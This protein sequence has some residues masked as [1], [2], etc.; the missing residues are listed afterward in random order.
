MQKRL[1]LESV[2]L[3]V[4]I[5]NTLFATENINQLWAETMFR[6]KQTIEF[7]PE[8]DDSYGVVFRDLNKDR[9]A[10]LYVVRF[11]NLNR[12][13][14][15]KGPDERF[16]DFTIQSGLGGNLMPRKRYNLE[17]GTS[18]VDFDNNGWP[19]ILIAGWRVLT[20]FKHQ[21]HL[22]FISEDL[23]EVF[24]GPVDANAGVWA[25]INLDGNL[26]LFIT[27]EHFYNRLLINLG[28]GRL[29]SAEDLYDLDLYPAT[30]Q[31]AAF[32]DI[33]NDGYPDLYVCNWFAPDIFYKNIK[34]EKYEPIELNLPHLKDSL[35]SNGICFGDIDN[36][37][38]LDMVVTDRNGKSCLYRNDTSPKDSR[39]R[40][41]DITK[42]AG[43][44]NNWPSY[45]SVIADLNNDGFQDIF[46]T[47]IGP[48][49]FYLNNSDTNFSLIFQ[50]EL[51][52]FSK[53]QN[54]STGTAVADLDDDGDLDL[55]VANKDTNSILYLNPLNNKDFIRIHLEG[56]T[57]NRDAIGTKIWL[58]RLVDDE[59]FVLKAFREISGGSGYLSFGE[60]IA[61]FGVQASNLYQANIRFPSGIEK[62]LTE[63]EPGNSYFVEEFGG[64]KKALVQTYRL[65]VVTTLK[66]NFWLNL[67]LFI[68]MVTLVGGFISFSTSR[69]NWKNK[70]SAVFLTGV[71][72][73]LYLLFII[74]PDSDMLAIILTQM[75]AILVL[76]VVTTVF[77]EKIRQIE[78]KRYGYRNLLQQFSQHS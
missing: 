8:F 7:L 36:D 56:I 10:D 74:R 41:T 39:W 50:E 49:Q 73:I 55:F 76:I 14:I 58:H 9:L 33:D 37:A 59:S 54:Y 69:Y 66:K 77:M 34:G 61:H 45:G 16:E 20:F 15:N 2:L 63:L 48:N 70:Q 4:L 65:A 35:N 46:F 42:K 5:A 30:S 11:R 38:D 64:P 32:A 13:F 17:L 3:G 23:N 28:Y 26:D 52:P 72:I 19:D 25:D 44:K 12:L 53:N 75:G 51:S 78:L 68:L 60:P 62:V 71:L 40:F 57:S 67:F 27:D 1:I 31:G 43:I 21:G 47:N 18:A 24:D 29:E 6:S 22:E